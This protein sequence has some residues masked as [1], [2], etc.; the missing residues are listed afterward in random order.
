MTNQQEE[1]RRCSER[2]RATRSGPF[3]RVASVSTPRSRV[4]LRQ[5]EVWLGSATKRL[6]AT[7]GLAPAPSI[8]RRGAIVRALVIGSISWV[9]VPT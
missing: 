8:P 2:N 4:P 5:G 9:A 7:P 1:E 6:Q 3:D